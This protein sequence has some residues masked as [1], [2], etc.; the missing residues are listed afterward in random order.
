[1]V[2]AWQYED[3]EIYIF[4]FLLMIFN[5]IEVAGYVIYWSKYILCLD[6]IWNIITYV[7]RFLIEWTKLLFPFLL[8]KYNK[9]PNTAC[10]ISVDLNKF[11]SAKAYAPV[12]VKS[13]KRNGGLTNVIIYM[14]IFTRNSSNEMTLWKGTK[15]TLTHEIRAFCCQYLINAIMSL[16]G[17]SDGWWMCC[18][19]RVKIG[20]EHLFYSAFPFPSPVASWSHG[21]EFL[22]VKDI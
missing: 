2:F 4:L 16:G 20:L 15:T 17:R 9:T 14:Q 3:M 10:A 18:R 11:A 12:S 6:T 13:S 8:T 21:K 19:F 5:V 1:M 22:K 7:E